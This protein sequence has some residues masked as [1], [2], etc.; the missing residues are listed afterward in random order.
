M[1]NISRFIGNER[2]CCGGSVE[3]PD[4]WN[5]MIPPTPTCVQCGARAVPQGPIIQTTKDAFAPRWIPFSK[6]LK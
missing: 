3:T 5:S 6:E 2:G 1:S 4:L